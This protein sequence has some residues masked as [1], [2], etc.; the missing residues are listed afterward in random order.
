MRFDFTPLLPPIDR[1]V[2]AYV[3]TG[4]AASSI[5]KLRQAG[6]NR[7]MLAVVAHDEATIDA[8]APA[9]ALPA[10]RRDWSDSGLL[11]GV[12]WAAL[13]VAATSSLQV[14]AMSPAW[15]MPIGG[16]ALALHLRILAT[17]MSSRQHDALL[18]VASTHDPRADTNAT[19]RR[20]H[21]LVVVNVGRAE[22]AA[23]A[24]SCRTGISGSPHRVWSCVP[25]V[26]IATGDTRKLRPGTGSACLS[27][28]CSASRTW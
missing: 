28:H 4:E 14:N 18:M 9:A 10:G 21:Y 16:T 13:T 26:R 17:R 24:K 1:A 20:N 19:A 22:V 7:R 25:R 27:G 12:L 8:R 15:L 11:W 2:V 3:S 23:A 5:E 6:F